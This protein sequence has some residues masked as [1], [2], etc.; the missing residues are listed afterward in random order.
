MSTL[1]AFSALA[2]VGVAAAV[3]WYMT[4]RWRLFCISPNELVLP[5]MCPMC[6]ST[7][8][9][10]KIYEKSSERQTADYVIARRIEWWNIQVPHCSACKRKLD[11]DHAI[12]FITGAASIGAAGLLLPPTEFS[13]LLLC[14]ILFGVPAYVA[15]TTWRKGIVFGPSSSHQI[16]ARIR[17]PEYFQ[18]LVAATHSVPQKK[19]VIAL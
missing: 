11:T 13:L 8:V 17:H 4:R 5:K 16:S 12:G 7:N 10:E 14:Y 18:S 9:T 6:L 2:M 15:A 19:R 3:K 1:A